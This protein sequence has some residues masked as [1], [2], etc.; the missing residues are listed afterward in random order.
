M[1]LTFGF[2]GE[3]SREVD[4]HIGGLRHA[5]REP[6]SGEA[7]VLPR[8]RAGQVSSSALGA[9]A[10]GTSGF[11]WVAVL[12]DVAFDVALGNRALAPKNWALSPK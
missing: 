4:L 3:W 7:R 6:G 1:G 2:F 12:V 5:G 11:V 8:S 10:P 9:G